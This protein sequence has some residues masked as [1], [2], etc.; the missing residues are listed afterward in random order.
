MM[1]P[2]DPHDE[3]YDRKLRRASE[4]GDHWLRLVVWLAIIVVLL[5]FWKKVYSYFIGG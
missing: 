3:Y 2:E 1:I 5:L 4:T